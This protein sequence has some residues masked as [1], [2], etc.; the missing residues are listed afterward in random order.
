VTASALADAD[1]GAPSQLP[2]WTIGHVLTHIARNADGIRRMAQGAARGEVVDQYEGGVASRAADIEA[3]ARRPADELVDDV[4][5]SA[6][7]LRATWDAM[8]GGAWANRTRPLG[9]ESTAEEG[10]VAR[11]FEV[12]VHHVDLG[13]GYTPADWPATTVDIGLDRVVARFRRHSSAIGA[14]TAWR[15]VRTD[16]GPD[17]TVRRDLKGTAVAVGPL[18]LD[19]EPTATVRAP[20]SAL[21]AWLLGRGDGAPPGEVDGDPA[22]AAALP[23]TYPWQ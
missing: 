9:G 23:A 11:L 16:G 8:P 13:R 1:V 19:R 15:L 4:R 7:A 21:L 5:T 14:P 12:E 2:G 17:V 6:A 20:G 10:P 3:G 18:P 22:V